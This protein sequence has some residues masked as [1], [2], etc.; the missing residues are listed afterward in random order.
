MSIPKDAVRLINLPP[1]ER[2]KYTKA[3]YGKTVYVRG[4]DPY[5]IYENGEVR[6]P[7]NPSIHKKVAIRRIFVKPERKSN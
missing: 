3:K 1:E 2:E 5:A 7:L 6:S 4:I